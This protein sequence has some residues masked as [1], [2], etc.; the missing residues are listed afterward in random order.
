[1]RNVRGILFADYVRMMRMHKPVQWEKHLEPEDLVH[2]REGAR[3]DPSA[4]Y[5]M[6]TFERMGNAIL[7]EIANRDVQAVRMWGRYSVDSLAAAQPGLV[8]AGDPVETL[9]RFRVLRATY[10]D[11]EALDVLMLTDGEAQVEIRYHMGPQAE[12]AASYQT[13]GFFERLLELAGAKEVAARFRT[14]A[15]AG[16][17]RTVLDLVWELA[18]RAQ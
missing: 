17:E 6:E 11:F 7:T 3:I 16:D 9:M 18:P 2:L 5:P 4:W 1:V 15:W 8:A 13:M 12:E 10:F 14:R